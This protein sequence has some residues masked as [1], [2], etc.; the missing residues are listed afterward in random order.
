ML[1]PRLEKIGRTSRPLTFAQT[2]SGKKALTGYGM[3]GG[4]GSAFPIIRC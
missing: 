2:P 4:L 3:D 1:E